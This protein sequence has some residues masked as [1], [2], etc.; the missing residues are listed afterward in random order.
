MKKSILIAGLSL[1]ALS[2]VSCQKEEVRSESSVSEPNFTLFAQTADTKT[3][4]DGL[5]IKWVAEDAINVFHAVKDATTYTSDGKFTVSDVE[6]GKFAGTVSGTLSEES[7]DWYAFY[8][9]SPSNKTPAGISSSTFDYTTIGGTSQTQVGNNSKA[10][11]C[12][13]SCPLYGIAKGVDAS[14][15]PEITMNQLTSVIKVKVTNNSGDALT[16][17]KVAFTGTEDIVGVYYINFASSSIAYKMR[18]SSYVSN[19]ATLT[20]SDGEAI[21][22]ESSAEFFIA[23]KPF[24]ATSGSD[25]ELSVNGYTKTV[26]LKSDL[27]FTAGHIKTLNFDYDTVDKGVTW[28]FSDPVSLGIVKPASG[29]GTAVTGPITVGDIT[30]TTTSGSTSTRVYNSSGTCDFRVYKGGTFTFAVPDGYIITSV[31]MT[32]KSLNAITADAGTYSNGAWTGQKQKITFT[33]ISSPVIYTATI[34]YREGAPEPIITASDVTDVAA[35]GVDGATFTYSVENPIEG[36]QMEVVGDGTVVT[37]AIE[38]DGKIMYT[39]SKN[40]TTAAR[41]GKITL[42]YGNVEKEVKVSQVVSNFVVSDTEV[43]LASAVSSEN[44]LKVTSDFDW[45]AEASAKAGFTFSPN[46]YTWMTGGEQTVTVTASAA[47]ASEEG[48]I[49]IGT[50]TFTNAETKE[51]KTVTVKQR[52]SYT[53]P[54][55]LGEDW[56]SLFGTNYSGN[57]SSVKANKLT[58][59]GTS[60]NVTITVK[61]GSSTSGYVKTGDLRAYKNYTITLSVPSG[62]K[63]TKVTTTNSGAKTFDSG[64]TADSGIGSI[65]SSCYTWEGSTQTLKLTISG[66]VSFATITVVYE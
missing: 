18:G 21:S 48:T 3:S 15:S 35:R 12:G 26:T 43:V 40:T 32:G 5:N 27:V 20:V 60:G 59:S 25:I 6:T 55:T 49:T 51:V 36:T 57:I 65:S 56:N 45:A 54:V 28:D 16:V 42:T 9:Y 10:H 37:N 30:L 63:I 4:N 33:A 44:T 19:T 34:L 22:N 61:N 38:S 29:A 14:E 31:V 47:N 50:I 23:I 1:A 2:F 7:Y 39:V 66:A 58:L 52:S 64:I 24:T 8:P 17:N 41:E 53:R 13:G 46:K 11:L 62:N